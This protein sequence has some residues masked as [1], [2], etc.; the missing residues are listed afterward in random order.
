MLQNVTEGVRPALNKTCQ[1]LTYAC[2]VHLLGTKK[3]HITK[4]N[5]EA[6]QGR[7]SEVTTVHCTFV[8][9]EQNV[10]HTQSM[11]KINSL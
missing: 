9:H 5:T 11:K 1:I 2:D 3:M 8:S 4:K 6:L 7:W 10:R